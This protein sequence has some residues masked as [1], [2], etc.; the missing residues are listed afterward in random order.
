MKRSDLIF[1][2]I[3]IPLDA[4]MIIA[5]G[6]AAYF[7]RFQAFTALRP[8]IF[9]IPFERYFQWIALVTLVYLLLFALSGLYTI[10][11]RRIRNELQRIDRKSV[12]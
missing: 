11:Y 8:V 5:A 4:L 6:L 9:E 3:L 7:L 2:L 10:G 1:A 12:V